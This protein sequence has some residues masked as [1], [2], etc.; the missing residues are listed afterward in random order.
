M[1]RL[2]IEHEFPLETFEGN[3]EKTGSK[4]GCLELMS[5]NRP[6]FTRDLAKGLIAGTHLSLQ[7]NRQQET[8]SNIESFQK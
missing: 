2:Q 4:H 3:G 6:R 1:F 8:E 7:F 5:F